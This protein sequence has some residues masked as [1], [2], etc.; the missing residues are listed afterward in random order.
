MR[1]YKGDPKL[2]KPAFQFY[3]RSAV[4]DSVGNKPTEFSKQLESLN[5]SVPCVNATYERVDSSSNACK[6]DGNYPIAMYPFQYNGTEEDLKAL[7]HDKICGN[8]SDAII[9]AISVATNKSKKSK[10][11]TTFTDW[12][13]QC[14]LTP[15]DNDGSTLIFATYS[16][17][18]TDRSALTY[19]RAQFGIPD[20][21]QNFIC[22]NLCI[23]E[24]NQDYSKS[25]FYCDSIKGFSNIPVAQLGFPMNSETND[26]TISEF[27]DNADTALSVENDKYAGTLLKVI[28][29]NLKELNKGVQPHVV[30]TLESIVSKCEK[31]NKI[32]IEELEAFQILVQ[33]IQT[34]EHPTSANKR[35]RTTAHPQETQD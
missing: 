22:K 6:M 11:P 8:L 35:Q 4:M 5:M 25:I 27:F 23:Y 10:Y 17:M 3:L 24:R 20:E 30:T 32:T 14:D 15:R 18:V 7:D 12:S 34:I 29:R 9:Q 26:A 2:D 16:S 1:L 33:N 31:Q 21:D 19:A 13:D 28:L